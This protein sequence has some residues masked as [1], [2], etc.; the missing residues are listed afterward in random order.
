MA[1]IHHQIASI[2]LGPE[3]EQAALLFAGAQLLA[4][5]VFLEPHRYAD[6]PSISNLWS[7]E[8]G[9]GPCQIGSRTVLFSSLDDAQRW[10]GER[11]DAA[12]H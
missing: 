11:F 7:V 9:F 2:Q 5:V 12:L 10:A 4:I 6:D 1:E 3:P 8:I